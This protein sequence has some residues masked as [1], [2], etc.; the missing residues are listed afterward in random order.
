MSQPKCNRV[1]FKSDRWPCAMLLKWNEIGNKT[2]ESEGRE[3]FL[4]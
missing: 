2:V 1:D 4:N 3:Y